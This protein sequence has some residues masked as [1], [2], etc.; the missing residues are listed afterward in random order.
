M[1][2]E[3]SRITPKQTKKAVNIF[4]LL[5]SSWNYKVNP[6]NNISS[7]WNCKEKY[8]KKIPFFKLKLQQQNQKIVSKL[9]LQRKSE[10]YIFKLKLQIKNRKIYYQV[11]T[12]N[13][14]RKIFFRVEIT[15]EN[16]GKDYF[17]VEA[18]KKNSEYIF[19][20]WNCK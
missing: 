2:M 17:Q 1:Q 16:P 4:F 6:I 15:K 19:S 20:I 5:M 14:I 13:K 8:E 10:K 12:T 7:S 18:T 3:K 11:E 9:K